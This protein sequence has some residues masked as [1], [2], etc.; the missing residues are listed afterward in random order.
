VPKSTVLHPGTY[1][2]P[3]SGGAFCERTL[4]AGAQPNLRLI[5]SSQAMEY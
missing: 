5:I 2:G 3:D 4:P 1:V